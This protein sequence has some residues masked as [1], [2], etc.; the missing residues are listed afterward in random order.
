MDDTRSVLS[1]F[2]DDEVINASTEIRKHLRQAIDLK[3]TN[4]TNF[5]LVT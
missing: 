3:V 1:L 4:M 2:A 5:D